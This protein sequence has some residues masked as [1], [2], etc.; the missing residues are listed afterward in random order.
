MDMTRRELA[1]RIA[2]EASQMRRRLRREVG[3][4]TLDDADSV[5]DLID[6]LA[7]LVGEIAPVEC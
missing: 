2:D 1:E 3:P 6:Q 4:V 5:L 7:T